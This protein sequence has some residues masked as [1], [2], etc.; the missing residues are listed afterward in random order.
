M[1]ETAAARLSRLLA[2]IPWLEQHDGI[3]ITE[4]AEHFGVTPQEIERDL[5]LTICCG[6]P[7]HGPDQLIDIQFWDDDGR[8]HVIDPQTLDRPL[9]LSAGESTALLVGLR[10]LGQVPG[11][12]DRSAL[13]SAT[14]K[15]EA[16]VDA[17]QGAAV[18]VD[19]ADERI[20]AQLVDAIESGRAVE[21]TYAGASRDE[22]TTRVVDPASLVMHAGRRYLVAWCHSADAQRTFRLDRI[23]ALEVLDRPISERIADTSPDGPIAP[24]AGVDVR[25]RVAAR[26]RWFLEAFDAMEWTGPG[27][28]ADGPGWVEASVVVA[29][30]DWLA[31]LVV[32]QGG[33]VEVLEPPEA[34]ARVR[35]VAEEALE[36]LTAAGGW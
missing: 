36:R 35:A 8:I 33:G 20:A 18:V 32:A 9:R 19:V 26:S 3:S 23:L 24:V 5:W 34:R 25:L 21:I 10:L 22:V 30:P 29:D 17:A 31:R 28:D 13:A 7:G 2:L 27:P 12:H 11:D 15:L 6:L 4:A 1:R 14:A 16:A